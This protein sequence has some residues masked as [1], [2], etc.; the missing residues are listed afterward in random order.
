MMSRR[1][2]QSVA[3]VGFLAVT[4][5]AQEAFCLKIRFR[6]PFNNNKV[7]IT[8]KDLVRGAAAVATGG[9]SEVEIARQ[10]KEAEEKAARDRAAAER[11]IREQE[12]Q[13]KTQAINNQIAA[14]E[15]ELNQIKALDSETQNAVGRLIEVDMA[16]EREVVARREWVG[17]V[18]SLYNRYF[19]NPADHVQVV[20][21]LVASI[22]AVNGMAGVVSANGFTA[23][24]VDVVTQEVAHY[25]AELDERSQAI[26]QESLANVP[27]VE[28][29]ALRSATRSAKELMQKF[30]GFVIGQTSTL[31]A[32]LVSLRQQL[33][34]L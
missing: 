32:Q 18:K 33:G 11:Q 22:S 28:L 2:S 12:R 9:L 19:V 20:R 7:Q 1:K 24:P 27:A 29:Q 21:D 13:A 3:L 4:L 34:Q 5:L 26:V 10:K 8:G 15:H 30:Q 23:Q 14:L 31:E 6:N 17:K 25:L 16:I